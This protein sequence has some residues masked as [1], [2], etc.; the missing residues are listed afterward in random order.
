VFEIGY[1]GV[2]DLNKMTEE[3]NIEI[4]SPNAINSA[5]FENLE[6]K[7]SNSLLKPKQ[8]EE[9]N[10]TFKKRDSEA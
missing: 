10:L 7:V 3:E 6:L 5:E 8:K 1:V 9:Y 2:I 4:Q